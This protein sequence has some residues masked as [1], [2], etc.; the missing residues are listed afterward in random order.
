MQPL[1]EQLEYVE[2]VQSYSTKPPTMFESLDQ[3]TQCILEEY[4]FHQNNKI[5]KSKKIS[6][7]IKLFKHIL[8][9]KRF[10]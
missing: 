6:F 3:L 7:P 5:N 4:Q 9:Q 8:S 10:E 2:K 1:S